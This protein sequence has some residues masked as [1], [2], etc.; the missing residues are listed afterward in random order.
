MRFYKPTSALFIGLM[1]IMTMPCHGHH[2]M[3][4]T[5]A[6]SP[7]HD[8]V[9]M[10]VVVYLVWEGMGVYLVVEEHIRWLRSIYGG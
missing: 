5:M 4:L 2:A 10:D 3:V 7:W 1:R 8:V 9:L 6:W